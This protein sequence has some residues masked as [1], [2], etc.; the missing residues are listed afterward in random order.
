M[1][2]SRI[3]MHIYKN[4]FVYIYLLIYLSYPSIITTLCHIYYRHARPAL[5]SAPALSLWT[6]DGTPSAST[7]S[8]HEMN[9]GSS[10]GGGSPGPSDDTKTVPYE[11]RFEAYDFNGGTT[12]CISGEDF[13][14]AAGCTRMTTGR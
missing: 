12:I 13:A 8:L 10:S 6:T 5:S 2:L 3:C 7:A 11:R 14:I 9:Y 4:I 1:Y